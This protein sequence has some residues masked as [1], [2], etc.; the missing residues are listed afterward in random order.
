MVGRKIDCPKCKYRFVVTEPPPAAPEEDLD[1]PAAGAG[2]AKKSAGKRS[3]TADGGDE[4]ALEGIR[5]TAAAAKP[6]T[7]KPHWRDAWKEA[8]KGAPPVPPPAVAKEKKPINKRALTIKVGIVLGVIAVVVLV[9]GLIVMLSRSPNDPKPSSGSVAQR[10]R[11]ETSS[12]GSSGSTVSRSSGGSGG[13]S[14]KGTSSSS[15]PVVEERPAVVD[16]SVYPAERDLTAWLPNETDTV[17]SAEGFSSLLQDKEPLGSAI[18]HTTGGF[19]RDWMENRLGFR[20]TDV[21]RMIRAEGGPAERRWALTFVRMDRNRELSPKNLLAM[22]GTNVREMKASNGHPYYLF[23]PNILVDGIGD[24]LV[25]KANRRMNAAQPDGGTLAF[26]RFGDHSTA[27]VGDPERL[28]RL[29]EE[30]RPK[31]YSALAPQGHEG[32]APQGSGSGSASPG[33][34]NKASSSGSGSGSTSAKAGSSASKSA[35]SSASAAPFNGPPYSTLSPDL[36]TLLEQMQS[37]YHQGKSRPLA[38]A[39]TSRPDHDLIQRIDRI[40]NSD[41]DSL[42]VGRD[43]AQ[44]GITALAFAV[45]K[46]ESRAVIW[47]V[48]MR[49]EQ[50]DLAL[51]KLQDLRVVERPILVKRIK[52]TLG[53]DIPDPVAKGSGSGSRSGSGSGSGSAAGKPPPPPVIPASTLSAFVVDRLSVFV[54]ADLSWPEPLPG[55]P[56]PPTDAL[57]EFLRAA[58]VHTKCS[59]EMMDTRQPLSELSQAVAGYVAAMQ[60][61]PR[62]EDR[63]FPRGALRR[64]TKDRDDI[65]WPMKERLSWMVEL[66]PYLA[67][68]DLQQF[69]RSDAGKKLWDTR[70]SLSPW[71]GE[72]GSLGQ[73]LVPQFLVERG[74]NEN[75]WWITR[76]GKP[77][78]A[79][80]HV[81]GVAGVGLDIAHATD[82]ADPAV[83]NNAGILGFDRETRFDQIKGGLGSTILMIQ[84]P[85]DLPPGLRR[86]E[87]GPVYPTPWLSAG[88]NVRGVP[89]N[90]S[91]D[92][93]LCTERNGKVGTHVIMADGTVRFLAKGDITDQ[94]FKALCS[95]QADKPANLDTIAPIVYSPSVPADATKGSGSG[96]DGAK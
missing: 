5:A 68:S 2:S 86:P 90:N 94:Q 21:S 73:V 37:S 9:G 49:F 16:T 95:I 19:V 74:T 28:V 23:V 56:S 15:L 53:I 63:K 50:G 54:T 93:F 11:P 25:G 61:L 35:S 64:S 78:V 72:L 60:K 48:G 42:M 65:P 82:L 22:L 33:L 27:M 46:L 88:G 57:V 47:T 62:A 3:A 38:V 32:A 66:L 12:S 10:P 51:S 58:T 87:Y 85:V 45:H 44:E 39:A 24:V 77:P 84:V 92:A 4:T 75:A 17:L 20:L 18:F 69:L 71:Q 26:Y 34:G 59:M 40:L 83:A 29:V 41:I 36:A 80:T 70:T 13:D 76:V 43:P 31:I 79:A 67:N 52:D 14:A 55:K 89:E 7:K 1:E 81:V 91:L 30:G 6:D 96:S 8:D